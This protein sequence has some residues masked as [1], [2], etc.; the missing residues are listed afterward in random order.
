MSGAAVSQSQPGPGLPV[1]RPVHLNELDSNASGFIHVTSADVSWTVRADL[2]PQLIPRLRQ[3]AENP[4]RDRAIETVKTGPHRTVYRLSLAAA[5]YYLKHFR[6]N[7]WKSLL[8]NAVRPAKAV[9][10]WRAARRIAQLGL[11]TFEAVALGQIRRNGLV[12][13]SFLVSLGIPQAIP[14]DEFTALTLLPAEGAGFSA[15]VYKTDT[16]EVAA[17]GRR[18]DLGE[19]QQS[20]LRQRLAV[21][22]GQVA[23]RLHL[24]AVEHA[25]FHAANILV[26]LDAEGKPA[27]WLIDLHRVYF[28]QVLSQQQRYNNLAFLHQFFTDK[29]SRAD[30]LRF[31][32]AY[33]RAAKPDELLH[34]HNPDIRQASDEPA[35]DRTEIAALESCLAA[36]AQR[37][38]KRADRA[39]RR[40]NRHVR[41]LDTDRGGCRGIK[42]LSLA[43][44]TSMRDHPERLFGDN[45]LHWHKQTAKHRVAQ[46]SFNDPLV[47]PAGSAFFKCV[48]ERSLLR[49]WLAPFRDSPVRKA[50][51]FGHAL[52]R[53]HVDTPRPIMFV[54]IRE[55]QG[56]KCYLLTETVHDT[57]NLAEF[58]SSRWPHLAPPDKRAWLDLHLRRLAWQMRRLH[59]SGF[60]H[61]DLKFQNLLVSC[62]PDDPRIWFLDLE[63]MS[64]WRHIPRARAA[65]NL[66]RINVS[67][68]AHEI[69]S[70]SDRLRFL[71][72]YLTGSAQPRRSS[73]S[74]G[75]SPLTTVSSDPASDWKDWWRRIAG[76]SERKFETNRRRGR[77]IH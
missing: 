17:A 76:I 71:K 63:G 9:L 65:Q 53:R 54:E 21:A 16:G 51:E 40:G 46:I 56:R 30:R 43:A 61:R 74:S 38:W 26:R 28:R 66:A 34:L 62:R 42:A 11:P 29:S 10:E 48:E 37:G 50:W 41:K 19:R 70:L 4:A 18:T 77:A 39:W 36:G 44:L 72:Q 73:A 32:R 22:L 69:A 24:A 31:Y 64:A 35:L 5:E 12:A 33:Q 7:D 3:A 8:V 47:A 75:S 13:D 60:D 68:M 23:G 20:E 15:P 1:Q 55:D 25:D 27:L 57:V 14:L 67:A 45:V 2:A 6:I 49:R 52:L 58:L 59:S